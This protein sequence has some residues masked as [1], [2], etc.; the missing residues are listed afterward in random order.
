MRITWVCVLAACGGGGSSLE[1]EQASCQVDELNYVHTLDDGT[2]EGNF[3]VDGYIF[4]NALRDGNGEEHLG[5]LDLRAGTATIV[6]VEFE[7]LLVGG[8]TVDARGHVKLV[9]LGID[10]GNCETASFSGRI[11][12]IA[13]GWSFTLEDLRASPYCSGAAVSGAIA[14]CILSGN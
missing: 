9:D 8:G 14:G 13:G 3:P 4:A 1:V 12:D 2:G 11:S 10:V 7:D 6:H 5:V